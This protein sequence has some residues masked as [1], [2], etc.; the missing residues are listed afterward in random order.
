MRGRDEGRYI[1]HRAVKWEDWCSH[2]LSW[3]QTRWTDS[4][5][6]E[7]VIIYWKHF[8]NWRGIKFWGGKQK[9]RNAHTGN[10]LIVSCRSVN[11]LAFFS[12]AYD[13]MPTKSKH[14]F[15]I[16]FFFFIWKAGKR[17]G[18]GDPRSTGHYPD[19]HK[20]EIDKAWPKPW[21]R[22]PSCSPTRVSRT[23]TLKLSTAASYTH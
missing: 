14:I 19:A 1:L 7:G 5:L 6:L 13:V 10:F 2:W 3:W 15:R 12:I 8:K 22:T 11:G 17:W 16:I 20:I 23:Q 4:C 21:T 9:I 18:F